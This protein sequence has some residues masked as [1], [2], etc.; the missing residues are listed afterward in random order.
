MKKILCLFSALALVLTSC[1]SDD[2]SSDAG[3][4]ALLPTKIVETSVEN[5]KSGSLTY[6]ATYDGNKIKEIKVSDASRSV[7]TYTGDLITKVELYYSS[8]LQSTDVYAYENGKLISKI[9]TKAFGSSPQQKLTFVYN[10]NGTVNANQSQIDNKVETKFDATTLYT[11]ANGNMI[12][13]EFSDAEREK[14]T[15]TFDDKKSPFVNVTGLK[16]LLDLDQHLEFDFYSVNNNVKSVTE[17][18]DGEGKLVQTAT[19]ASTNKYNNSNFLT[20]AFVGDATDSY[21][22]E[23]TY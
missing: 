12:S 19:V 21:K 2:S 17:T 9:T 13:S 1:S 4:A 11:F 10:A 8:E 15:S 7:F 23:I 18:Y 6:T 5:G 3:S 14:I 20:E 16:L 22:L